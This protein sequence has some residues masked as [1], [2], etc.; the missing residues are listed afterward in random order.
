MKR[1]ENF[2]DYFKDIFLNNCLDETQL[3][4][5]KSTFKRRIPETIFYIKMLSTFDRRERMVLRNNSILIKYFNAD[6]YA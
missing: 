5:S 3:L 4:L 6:Y 2:I 1:R